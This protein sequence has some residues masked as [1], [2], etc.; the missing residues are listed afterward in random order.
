MKL[1]AVMFRSDGHS[2]HGFVDLNVEKRPPR[3][4]LPVENWGTGNME[5]GCAHAE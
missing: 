2:Y 4:T 5:S 1:H 3:D